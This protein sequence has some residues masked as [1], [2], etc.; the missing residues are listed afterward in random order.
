L[1]DYFTDEP[2]AFHCE[3]LGSLAEPGKR[4]IARVAP[5]GHAKSTCAAFAYPLWCI[6]Q[7]R[8]RNIVIITHAAPLATQFVRDLRHELETNERIRADYGDLCGPAAGCGP[9]AECGPAASA[10]AVD[11]RARATPRRRKWSQHLFVTNTGI[12][13][14]GRGCGASFRGTRAG[15]HRPDL[16]ICDDI[17]SDDQVAVPERRRKLEHWLR[18]VVLPA[19]APQGQVVVLGSILHHDS[20]LANLRDKQA[21]PRWD[22]QVYRALEVA[23]DQTGELRRVPLWPARW[24]L[25]RLAEERQ[26]IGARAFE[27]EYQANPLDDTVRVFRPEWLKPYDEAALP[28]DRLLS[29]VAVD[30]ATGAAGGDFWALWVGGLDPETG[31]LY[32]RRLTLERISIVEQVL[33]VLAAWEE[34]RPLRIGIETVAYQVALK[35]VL[36]AESRRRGLYLP[37]VALRTIAN[38]RARI[39]AI[40]PLMENG[41]LRL[42]GGLDPEVEAQFLHFPQARHDD[43]PDVCALG[44]ELARTLRSG[45]R[46]ETLSGG[47]LDAPVEPGW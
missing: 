43:A 25:E 27:Q 26:R 33:R 18:R 10:G 3:L 21:W 5:R 41:T 4:L 40:A 6:C 23:P 16:V 39:E 17:E 46:V 47:A 32:T 1:P 11:D 7:R 28:H 30:P 13:V 37:L 12:T 2:A 44:V 8:R 24:P 34:W 35:D 45:L 31:V 19:L 42:P 38:K 15:P 20:L 36:E 22:Y 29:L 14:Q 9:A